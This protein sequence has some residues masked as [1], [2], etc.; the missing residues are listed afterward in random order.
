MAV[1]YRVEQAEWYDILSL[2]GT[3]PVTLTFT[4]TVDGSTKS[5]LTLSVALRFKG[6]LTS[7][8]RPESGLD[9]SEDCL[10]PAPEL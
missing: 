9:V 8:T 2:I 6:I 4:M 7:S 5:R 3:G 1:S 10:C